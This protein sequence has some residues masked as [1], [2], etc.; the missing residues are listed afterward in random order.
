[1]GC[2]L[3]RRL[4]SKAAVTLPLPLVTPKP[5][6]TTLQLPSVT[7]HPP[8]V[9]PKPP[10]TTLQLPSV[11]LHPPLVTPKPPLTTLQLP[12][13]TLHPPLV[14]PKPPLTTLQ[15]PLVTLQPPSVTL[16]P[17]LVTPST[18]VGRRPT[19]AGD[20]PTAV[21]YPLD[22]LPCVMLR[23]P[24]PL[25]LSAFFGAGVHRLVWQGPPGSAAPGPWALPCA[26]A[27]VTPRVPC[28]GVPGIRKVESLALL[29][30]AARATPGEF[31]WCVTVTEL[32][33]QIQIQIFSIVTRRSFCFPC[34]TT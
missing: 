11:T 16:Q 28:A 15:P 21:G 8:L 4:P 9:T 27:W 13:V 29:K 5:P 6:L 23:W 20:P 30:E 24:S 2:L 32:Q 1:M 14:T 31:P 33:I 10:L 18:A 12:S 19:A 7:L 34:Y 22:G 25:A 17:P 3:V 26:L